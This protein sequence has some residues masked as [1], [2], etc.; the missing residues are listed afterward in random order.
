MD[1]LPARILNTGARLTTIVA[2]GFSIHQRV[3][4]F[5]EMF[6]L[7]CVSVLIRNFT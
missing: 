5:A 7:H 1:Y 6:P 2:S 3:A 4:V